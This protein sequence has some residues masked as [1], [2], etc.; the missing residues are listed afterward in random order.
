MIARI[1]LMSLVST[2]IFVAAFAQ[3]DV[4]GSE[5]HTIISSNLKI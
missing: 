3:S 2:V 5:D 1:L 4:E